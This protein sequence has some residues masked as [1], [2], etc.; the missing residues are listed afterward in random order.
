MLS[1]SMSSQTTHGHGSIV[2]T[3][4]TIAFP[5]QLLTPP[6]EPPNAG[7]CLLYPFKIILD[8]AVPLLMQQ[9]SGLGESDK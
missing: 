2:K 5:A 3:F 1:L 8:P 7:L 9:E 4:P 6:P